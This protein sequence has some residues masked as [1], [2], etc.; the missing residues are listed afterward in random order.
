MGVNL[1]LSFDDEWAARISAM[2]NHLVGE[3]Q[4]QPLIIALLEKRGIASV[5]D[6]TPK[7]KAKLWITYNLLKDLVLFEGP[8]AAEAAN[9]TVAEDLQANFPLEIG[10][11]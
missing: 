3:R 11:A 2:V 7:Q 5:D 10:T 4:K 8:A 6:L 9:A 1:T